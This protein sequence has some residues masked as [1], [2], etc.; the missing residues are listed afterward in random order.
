MTFHLAYLIGMP[1][2]FFLVANM[3]LALMLGRRGWLRGRIV[4]PVVVR[5]LG[6]QRA[7]YLQGS[8]LRVALVSFI[9]GPWVAPFCWTALVTLVSFGVWILDDLWNRDDDRDERRH[10]WARAKLKKI[11]PVR[12][13]PAE[14]WAPSPA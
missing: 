5:L 3:K 13:R 8:L 14:R 6:R 4:S 2:I 10:E 7:L 9:V 11:R 12:L 1:T